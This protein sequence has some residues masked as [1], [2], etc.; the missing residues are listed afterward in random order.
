MRHINNTALQNYKGTYAPRNAFEGPGYERMDLRITQDIN[1][2]NDHKLIIYLDVLNLH[3][4][5]SDKKE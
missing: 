1:V 5:L 2:W 4:L 3:N